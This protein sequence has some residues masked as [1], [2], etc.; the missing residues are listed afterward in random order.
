MGFFSRLFGKK[1]EGRLNKKAKKAGAAAKKVKAPA[2]KPDAA[3]SGFGGKFGGAE[4]NAAGNKD[5]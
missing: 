3:L 4:Q 2:E 5:K 1:A